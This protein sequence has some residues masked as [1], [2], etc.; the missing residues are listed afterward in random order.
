VELYGGSST[1]GGRSG[2]RLALKKDM[3]EALAAGTE[4]EEV[5]LKLQTIL[6]AIEVAQM[7]ALVRAAQ[8]KGL[9]TC[10]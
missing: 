2:G 6:K 1:E 5:K 9:R 3:L 10:V 8:A 4:D 7:L